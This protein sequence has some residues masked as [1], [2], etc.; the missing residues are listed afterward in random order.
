MG[1]LHHI[2]LKQEHKGF[3]VGS[4][5]DDA[6]SLLENQDNQHFHQLILVLVQ[7]KEHN[8]LLLRLSDIEEKFYSD[9]RKSRF[10]SATNRRQRLA[11]SDS[12]AKP[13]TVVTTVYKRNPDV[14]AEVLE[15]SRG[16][17][18]KCKQPA[19]FLRA[20]DRTPYLEVHHKITLAEGGSDTVDNAMAVCPNCHRKL[21][22]GSE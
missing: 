2:G 15:R 3:F 22:Y 20:T 13:F 1:I 5:V 17:C 14:V 12:Q 18:E 11:E 9:V 21:H 19:P 7:F 10:S 8:S 6:I 4:T 16:I